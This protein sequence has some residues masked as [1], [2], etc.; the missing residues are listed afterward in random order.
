MAS[1]KKLKCLLSVLYIFGI[2]LQKKKKFCTPF[3][4]RYPE[5]DNFFF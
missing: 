1:D 2:I 5:N 4:R 3:L